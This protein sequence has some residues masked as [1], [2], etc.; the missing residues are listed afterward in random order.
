MMLPRLALP[1]AYGTIPLAGTAL[2]AALLPLVRQGTLTGPGVLPF[3]ICFTAAGLAYLAALVRLRRESPPLWVIWLFA[4]AF[5]LVMLATPVTLSEDVYRYAWDG[6]LLNQGVNPYAEPVQSPLLDPYQTPL[7]ERVNFAWMATPYL[8]AAQAYFALL[9]RLAPH[10]TFVFQLGAASL[11]LAAGGLLLLALRRLQIAVKAVLVYLWNP[12]VVVEFAHGAHVDALMLFFLA[13]ALVLSFSAGPRS[14]TLSALALAAAVL[15]K[16]LPA[17]A[18]PLFAARWGVNRLLLFSVAVALPLV[19]FASSAGWGLWGPQDGRGVFGALRIYSAAWAFN[20]GL[21]LW[22]ETLLASLMPGS[23]AAGFAR[24]IALFAPGLVGLLL[25]WHLWRERGMRQAASPSAHR[26]FARWVA[27]PL[28]L[29]LLLTPTVHPWYITLV[30]VLL[31]FFWP[32]PGEDPRVWRWAWPWVYFTFFSAF[33]YLAYT[34]ASAPP[35]LDLLRTAAYLPFWALLVWAGW[36]G[37]AAVFAGGSTEL[38]L[39][40]RPEQEAK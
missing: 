18:A 26:R 11:D 5:R 21:Y 20:S 40:A 3:L 39:P 4:A 6:H 38:P 24:L 7:R 16:G 10:S 29:Y 34:G 19:A 36:T 2:F 12:L 27:L 30:L 1:A 9:S 23:W 13:G 8:P 28:G 22:L 33:T 15:V 37:R 25:G 32:A 35:G 17:L 14:R 31:P